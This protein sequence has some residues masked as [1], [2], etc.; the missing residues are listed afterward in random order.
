MPTI[1][2]LNGL[3]NTFSI[4]IYVCSFCLLIVRL[5]TLILPTIL[6]QVKP[7]RQVGKGLK[8]LYQLVLSRWSGGGSYLLPWIKG[9]KDRGQVIAMLPLELSLMDTSYIAC[10]C[11]LPCWLLGIPTLQDGLLYLNFFQMLGCNCLWY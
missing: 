11:A 6:Y 8:V 4:Y 5:P 3:S 10:L 1:F 9:S 2:C 7:I